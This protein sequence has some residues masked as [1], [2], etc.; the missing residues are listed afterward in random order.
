MTNPKWEEQILVVEVDKLF[1]FGDHYFNGVLTNAEQVNAI[2][3]NIDQNM[4]VKRRGNEKDPTPAEYNMEIN[5]N[6]KQP[7]PY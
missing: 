1:G 6:Y 3:K 5:T 4:E 7:I 2:V